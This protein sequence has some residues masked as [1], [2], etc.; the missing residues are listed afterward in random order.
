MSDYMTTDKEASRN[1]DISAGHMLRKVVVDSESRLFL[2]RSAI[3]DAILICP[4]PC[5]EGEGKGGTPPIGYEPSGD[6][7]VPQF[8]K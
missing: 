7:G 5:C 1:S 4:L 6:E 8:Y 2:R 3:P